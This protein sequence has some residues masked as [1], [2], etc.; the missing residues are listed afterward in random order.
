MNQ[1]F[2]PCGLLATVHTDQKKDLQC[3]IQMDGISQKS[4]LINIQHNPNIKG[5]IVL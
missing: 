4:F 5:N 2:V 1:D 3:Y